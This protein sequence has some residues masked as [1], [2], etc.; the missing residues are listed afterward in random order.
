MSMEERIRQLQFEGESEFKA[1]YKLGIGQFM[2]LARRL[3]YWLDSD[4][5]KAVN[6]S[7]SPV[8]AE[9]RLSMAVRFFAGG[10]VKDICHMH[11]V[12]NST[13]YKVVWQVVDFINFY[14]P[15]A[16]PI[17]DPA[18]IERTARGFSN[19]TRTSGHFALLIG[20]FRAV[21]PSYGP[22]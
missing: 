3:D 22:F 9:L 18:V 11:G 14:F 10:Q 19:I 15:L 8:S 17:N 16:Y 5:S 20:L 7:G 2:S 4:P 12:H 6:S 1:T 13:F 21:Y